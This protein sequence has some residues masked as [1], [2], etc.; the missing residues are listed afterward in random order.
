[1]VYLLQML[2]TENTGW[3]SFFRRWYYQHEPLRNSAADLLR[4]IGATPI[5]RNGT[6]LVG[7]NGGC[8]G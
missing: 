5:L 8:D 1:M 2:A 7:D 3:K 6:R 4:E